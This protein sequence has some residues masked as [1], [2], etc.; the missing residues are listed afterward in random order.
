MGVARQ[1]LFAIVGEIPNEFREAIL[2]ARVHD[3]PPV[4]SDHQEVVRC[5]VCEQDAWL[6][7]SV[8]T[9]VDQDEDG[10]SQLPAVV[11]YPFMFRCSVCR[12]ALDGQEGIG[13][14]GLPADIEVDPG[15]FAEEK[16]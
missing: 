14:A 16:E 11:A 15:E 8:D 5:P 9:Y 6:V 3:L 4:W 12:L 7:C 13:L 2:A 10:S 1:R